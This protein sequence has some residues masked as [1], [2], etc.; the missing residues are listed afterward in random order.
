VLPCALVKYLVY[1]MAYDESTAWFHVQHCLKPLR[2]TLQKKLSIYAFFITIHSV[3]VMKLE[4]LISHIS[5]F[6]HKSLLQHI[7]T[8]CGIFICYQYN[9]CILLHCQAILTFP[10]YSQCNEPF[11]ASNT[12][13]RAWDYVWVFAKSVAKILLSV[14]K[15]LIKNT[16]NLEWVRHFCYLT[17]FWCLFL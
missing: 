10:S 1:R 13:C 12:W 7:N 6:S 3:A 14:V 17:K 15:S 4:N 2:P 11:T 8:S 16:S 9:T 5:P